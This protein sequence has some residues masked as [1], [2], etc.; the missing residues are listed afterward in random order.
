MLCG[1]T[2]VRKSRC[3]RRNIALEFDCRWK[4]PVRSNFILKLSPEARLRSEDVL[5]KNF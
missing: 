2:T 4:S 1:V 5:D 3:L